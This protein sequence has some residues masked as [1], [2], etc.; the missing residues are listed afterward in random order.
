M[1][2]PRC[3]K[4]PQGRGSIIFDHEGA[5][6]HRQQVPPALPG[7]LARR[8]RQCFGPDGRHKRYTV[9][10]RTKQDVIEALKKESD[11]LD[12]GL[13]TSRSCNVEKASADWLEHGLPGPVRTHAGGL[14]GCVGPAPGQERQAT[15]AGPHRREVEAGL[16]SLAGPCPAG[17]CRSLTIRCAGRSGMRRPTARSAGTRPGLSIPDGTGRA[18]Q[19]GVHARPGGGADRRGTVAASLGAARR[20]EGYGAH[21]RAEAAELTMVIARSARVCQTRLQPRSSPAARIG[22]SGRSRSGSRRPA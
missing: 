5:A 20:A 21:A 2:A 1:H 14:P 3:G 17:P 10:G 16:R 11:E 8:P 7:P 4:G 18:A 19:A 6:P 9:S 12:A 22:C 15:A 13:S